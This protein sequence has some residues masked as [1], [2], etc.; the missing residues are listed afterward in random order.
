MVNLD[1]QEKCPGLVVVGNDTDA[2]KT[3]VSAI[4]M[5][6]LKGTYWKPIQSGASAGRDLTLIQHLT[7]L[8]NDHFLDEAY[9]F[10]D[11]LS[12]NQ[13]AYIEGVSI[14]VSKLALPFRSE[15]KHHPLIVETAG[16]IMVPLND[17]TM[18][19]DLIT[20]WGLPV[21]IVCRNR[22]GVINHMLLTI[23]ELKRR[24]IK[25][26]GFISSGGNGN[27]Q[28]L[29]DI[30][31][32]SG[33]SMIGTVPEMSRIDIESIGKHMDQIDCEGLEASLGR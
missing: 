17:D 1:N 11:V 30:A 33:V 31:R 19:I 29:N 20:E 32:I 24:N 15:V 25:I 14:D 22:L 5:R 16:G 21:V 3:L 23:S 27:P 9:I 7:G 10:Q 12:P 28:S 6:Y 13:A 18:N 8:P 26:F 2:G 4:L